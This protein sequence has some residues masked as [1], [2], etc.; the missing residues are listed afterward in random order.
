M[1]IHKLVADLFLGKSPCCP[2]CG[3]IMEINHKDENKSNNR[4]D[5]LEYVTHKE[6]LNKSNEKR[7]IGLIKR[8]SK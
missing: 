8:F 2:T 5:N 4:V 7:R 1:A 6:N 3:S